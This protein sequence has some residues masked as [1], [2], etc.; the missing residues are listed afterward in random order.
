MVA[1]RP[2]AADLPTG[3][4][5]QHSTAAAKLPGVAASVVTTEAADCLLAAWEWLMCTLIGILWYLLFHN[6]SWSIA[7]LL[8]FNVQEIWKER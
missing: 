6:L 7:I 3:W 1:V 4:P 2:A 5:A 8:D